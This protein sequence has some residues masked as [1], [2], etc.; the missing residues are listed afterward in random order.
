MQSQPTL[1]SPN[2]IVWQLFEAL[3]RHCTRLFHN[4]DADEVRQDSAMA[5]VLA[6]QCVEVFM[7]V[8]FRVV[9]SEPEFSKSADQICRDL[10]DTR[11]GLDRKLKDWPKAVFG[12]GLELGQG[13]GQRFVTL[14]DMRHRLMHFTSSHQ[15]FE[16][17]NVVI[18]GLADTSVYDNLSAESAVQAL[19]TAEEFLCEVFRLRGIG[20]EGLPH[21]LHAWTGRPPA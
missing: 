17:D 5:I 19:R 15:T 14:K 18:H 1:S 4:P 2:R 10:A 3:R 16:H 9:V 12:K 21:A 13:P 8:F 20:A 11:F 7:N 6:V